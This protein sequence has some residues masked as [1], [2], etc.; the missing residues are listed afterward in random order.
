MTR[1]FPPSSWWDS[2]LYARWIGANT[3]AEL[4]GLGATGV[5]V[6]LLAP[7]LETL[8]SLV[9]AGSMVAT[10]L[11][12]E[13]L[14]VGALQWWVLREVLTNLEAKTWLGFTMLGAGIAWSLGVLPSALLNFEAEA[15]GAPPEPSA[16]LVYGLAALMGL[17]LGPMLATPQ[18]V[19]LRQHVAKAVWW[20]PANALA[21]AF[22]MVIIFVG[23]DLMMAGTSLL[24]QIAVGLGTLTLTGAVVGAV[25]GIALVWLVRQRR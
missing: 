12:S 17:A 5:L 13:G 7:K 20:I 3:L 2:G 19:A 1:T 14:V 22:G 25:H 15:G 18:W 8:N 9:L 24:S 16:A 21:W 6:A 11:L 4:I 23:I 10:G